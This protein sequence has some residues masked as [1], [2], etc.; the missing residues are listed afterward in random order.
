[1]KRRSSER[2]SSS[3][4]ST[5]LVGRPAR[6]NLP[7]AS[8]GREDDVRRLFPVGLMSPEEFA[9]REAHLI[10]LFPFDDYRYRDPEVDR[11]I[12]RLGDILFCRM[13]APTLEELRCTYLT[14][15]ER[16]SIAEQEAEMAEH[17]Y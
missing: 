8:P 2:G 9:A 5:A 10:L 6:T 12:A 4:P 15:A 1:M 3:L 16:A 11:W 17:G 7:P 14:H 13:G